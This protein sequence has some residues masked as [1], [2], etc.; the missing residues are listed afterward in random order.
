MAAKATTWKVDRDAKGGGLAA[1]A[2]ETRDEKAS[3]LAAKAVETR[4]EKASG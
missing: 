2:V 4:D 3:G 1:K